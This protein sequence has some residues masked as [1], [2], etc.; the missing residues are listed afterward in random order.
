MNDPEKVLANTIKLCR[1]RNIFLPTF[2]EMA[3]PETIPSQIKEELR[4]IFGAK[5]FEGEELEK[6]VDLIASREDH[7]I[8]TMVS[9]EHG[10]ALAQRSPV[11]AGWTTFW[12]FC[13]CGKFPCF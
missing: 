12:A 1:E 6:M 5:G 3:H 2:A 11:M 4:Q 7:W 13:I 8:D 9:E 10:M